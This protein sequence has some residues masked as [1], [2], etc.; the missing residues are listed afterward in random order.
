MLIDNPVVFVVL[1]VM[2]AMAGTRFFYET[3]MF[4][5]VYILGVVVA[6]ELSKYWGWM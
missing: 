4:S 2:V 6:T 5:L 1:F 3:V